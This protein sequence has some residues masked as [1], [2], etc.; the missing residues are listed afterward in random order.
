MATHQSVLTPTWIFFS[1]SEV[2]T[3]WQTDSTAHKLKPRPFHKSIHLWVHSANFHSGVNHTWQYYQTSKSAVASEQFRLLNPL[4]QFHL[5]F[6]LT[7]SH[8]KVQ[9]ASSCHNSS[10]LVPP[11]GTP[12]N[13]ILH[14]SDQ[15]AYPPNVPQHSKQIHQR[16]RSSLRS[17]SSTIQPDQIVS[18]IP[19]PSIVPADND[20][21]WEDV[22]TNPST[23]NNITNR[24]ISFTHS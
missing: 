4:L 8:F 20:P 22:P 18:P 12:F 23:N 5:Q 11:L 19:G 15:I 7:N 14:L 10:T 13:T 6:N 1:S 2:T 16:G 21:N 3:M 17:P 24:P 9:M